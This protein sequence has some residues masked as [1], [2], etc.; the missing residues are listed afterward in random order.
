LVDP[1][2]LAT[3]EQLSLAVLRLIELEKAVVEGAAAAPLAG[4]LSGQLGTL[5]GKNVVLTLCGGNIDPV[6]LGRV[7][8]KGLAADGRLVRFTA[9]I[10][11]RPGGLAR[12][13][14]LLA[15]AGASVKQ[16]THDREFSGPSIAFVDVNCIIETVNREHAETVLQTLRDNGIRCDQR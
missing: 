8:E 7:I 2:V 11:D 5:A 10:S 3:E 6:V 15:D 16:I 12:L 9:T 4:L 1:V 13:S 14:K